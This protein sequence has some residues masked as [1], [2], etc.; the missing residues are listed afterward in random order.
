MLE[1]KIS[2]AFPMSGGIE[3]ATQRSTLSGLGVDPRG[4]DEGY[5]EMENERFLYTEEGE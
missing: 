4:G 1:I 2:R 3:P 5:H